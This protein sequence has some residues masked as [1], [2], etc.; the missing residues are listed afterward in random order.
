MQ[1]H[2]IHVKYLEKLMPGA[3]RNRFLSADE[4]SNGEGLQSTQETDKEGREQETLL[5]QAEVSRENEA[6]EENNDR[7]RAKLLEQLFSEVKSGREDDFKQFL[8]QTVQP[9]FADPAQLSEFLDQPG[10]S[11]WSLIHFAV[12]YNRLAVVKLLISLNT[13]A[14]KATRD[15]WSAL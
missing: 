5:Y 6:R 8:L 13:D 12:Y 11:G 3:I 14:N 7:E 10:N 4:Q 2:K 1:Q 9:L 15:G